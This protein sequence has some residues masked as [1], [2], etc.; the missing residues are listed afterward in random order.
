MTHFLSFQDFVLVFILSVPLI[1]AGIVHMVAVKLDIL[2]YLKKPIHQRL[3]GLN[4][5]WRGFVVMPL[6]TLPGV[7]LAKILE[8]RFLVDFAIFSVN[9]AFIS[10]L[11]LGFAYCLA[12]LPN[13]WMKRRLGIK[14]GQTSDQWK[15]FFVI[16]DQADSAIGCALVYMFYFHISLK[17][18]VATIILGTVIHLLMNQILYYLK[19]RK[20]PF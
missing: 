19:L 9:S 20:N 10:A 12:E 8:E 18:V 2:S 3:F 5:T 17:V 16:I 13:S 11:L 7:Y 15:W 1:V 14:E 4:K 6:A